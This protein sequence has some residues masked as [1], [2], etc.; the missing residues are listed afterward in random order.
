MR[1]FYGILLAFILATAAPL[2]AS[3]MEAYDYPF[4]NSLEATVVGTPSVYR[5]DVPDRDPTREHRLTIFEDRA[6][7]KVFWY[8]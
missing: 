8:N 1:Y 3:A 4:V 5:A 6:V 7:P 2:Q